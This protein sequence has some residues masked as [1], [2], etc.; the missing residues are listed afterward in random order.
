MKKI[1]LLAITFSLILVTT[2]YLYGEEKAD[3]GESPAATTE[4]KTKFFCGGCHVLSYPRVMEK[5]YT[6]WNAGKHK[7]VGCVNCHYTP[8][9]LDVKVP[10]HEKIP[11]DE[12]TASEKKTGIEFMKAELE[13]L[14]KLTTVL[15]M[16]ES[17]VRTR[18]RLDD[19]SC[20][21]AKCHPTT[22]EGK[23]GEFWTKKIKFVESDRD[24]KTKRVITYVHKTHF[25]KTKFVEGQEMHCT[26]CH[27]HETEKEHFE[28]SRKK[29]FLCHFKNVKLN[30]GR[31]K[32]SLCHEIPTKPLQT[33]KKEG[34]D[35][36][37]K[38]I[39]HKSVEEAGVKCGACHSHS[40]RGDGAIK[41][42]KCLDCHDNEKPVTKEGSNKKLMH[43]K[44]VAAQNASCFNCHE[45]IEHN[46]NGDFIAIGRSLCQ[47]CHPDHHKYQEMLLLGEKRPGVS[48]V[49]S[50]MF[51]VSTNCQACHLEE[52]I[53]KGEK[54]A[55]GAGKACVA[56]HT[57]KHEGMVKE[58]KEKTEEEAKSA[59]EVEKEALK[60]VEEAKGK[61][62][63]EKIDAAIDMIKQ[64]QEGLNIVEYGGG[65]HNKKYS[66][67]LIDAAFTSFEDAIDLFCAA[68]ATFPQHSGAGTLRQLI[69]HVN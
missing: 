60:T 58:W 6:S 34:A 62:P 27:Q 57:E 64:G 39:T 56:C 49:P 47:S 50:L 18:P 38:P 48:N 63:Q 15:N 10:E 23:E 44:H 11:K 19:R 22:G 65:V 29:C 20:T 30:E 8:E 35:E 16:K 12:K 69:H 36:D 68:T 42:E 13:I 3:P 7:D 25:D 55:H 61:M 5:A 37:E 52:K 32:C 2:A 66:I 9:T 1:L 45:P 54:V 14:A 53:I 33:Q 67:M 24:D 41:Q 17:V 43:E 59:R 31:A 4:P 26:S 28:V 46:K 40:I 21:T 51:A